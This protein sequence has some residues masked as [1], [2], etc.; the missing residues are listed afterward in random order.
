MRR[1]RSR[2][3]GVDRIGDTPG[4]RGADGPNAEQE[5]RADGPDHD[6]QDQ[7]ET[8]SNVKSVLEPTGQTVIER[9]RSSGVETPQVGEGA[10]RPATLAGGWKSTLTSGFES[11]MIVKTPSTV[12]N[13]KKAHER[14]AMTMTKVQWR[15]RATQRPA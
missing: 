11:T 8:E 4:D 13:G 5:R 10:A 3:F 6:P 15:V 1:S 7:L 12:P 14:A 2:A 9:C